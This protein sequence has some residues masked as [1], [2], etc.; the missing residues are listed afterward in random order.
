MNPL[1]ALHNFAALSR[2]AG[3]GNAAVLMA[4]HMTRKV[5]PG[6]PSRLRRGLKGIRADCCSVP[7]HLRLATS[8][9]DAFGQIFIRHE[10][11]PCSRLEDIR[12]IVDCG[13]NI[14][15]ASLYLLDR[16]PSAS[17][18]AIEPDP[19]NAALCRRNLEPYG[20]R[21]SVETAGVWPHGSWESPT[22]LRLDRS[23][24]DR[25]DWAITVREARPD[26]PTDSKGVGMAAV[27]QRAGGRIDLLKMDIE[28]TEEILFSDPD[29]SWL[30]CV[31]NIAI[32][33][34]NERCRSSFAAALSAFEFESSR[35]GE[36]VFIRNLTPRR[37][38]HDPSPRP[39]AERVLS[40]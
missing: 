1:G 31:R 35:S 37:S 39:A 29:T 18:L 11:A 34:H 20:E 7:V 25:R 21:V 22:R 28:G 32:E 23:G 5:S 17:V 15:L 2:A 33:L 12:T 16:Y 14:G 9:K 10:Y 40:A 38:A 8:D 13:A 30:S 24:G 4:A 19:D 27:C 26:E 6:L 36:S 3:V